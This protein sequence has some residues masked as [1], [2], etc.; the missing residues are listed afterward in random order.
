MK[1]LFIHNYF[2]EMVPQCR[3]PLSSRVTLPQS[4]MT[5]LSCRKH[6]TFWFAAILSI[7]LVWCHN[8]GTLSC[9]CWEACAMWCYSGRSSGDC[10]SST[11]WWGLWMVAHC[12]KQPRAWKGPC[13]GLWNFTWWKRREE[14]RGGKNIKTWEKKW[15]IIRIAA[16]WKTC[17]KVQ[18]DW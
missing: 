5:A 14:K 10:A 7:K 2:S 3:K 15:R 1:I 9:D 13:E 8:G 12:Q 4:H 17:H 6:A 11:L 18:K 16:S